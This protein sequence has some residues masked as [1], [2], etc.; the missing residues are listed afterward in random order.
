MFCTSMS[1]GEVERFLAFLGLLLASLLVCYIGLSLILGRL[2]YADCLPLLE[3]VATLVKSWS[4]K[5][6]SYTVRSQFI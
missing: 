3:R 1:L 5:T 4:A 6:L 2:S